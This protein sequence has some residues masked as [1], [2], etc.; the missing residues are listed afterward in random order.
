[1][2]DVYNRSYK[3]LLREIRSSPCFGKIQ[4]CK[5]EFLSKIIYRINTIPII[6]PADGEGLFWVCLVGFAQLGKLFLKCIWQFLKIPK[7]S[8]AIMNKKNLTWL[9]NVY[10]LTRNYSMSVLI[11][12]VQDWKMDW[13]MDQNNQTEKTG[14]KRAAFTWPLD[15]WQRF[16]SSLKGK[17]KFFLIHIL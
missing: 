5:M 8:K 16:Q 14:K 7:M 3:T 11:K 2:W 4:R 9:V 12:T 10:C 13:K 15:T 1:M 17:G 6:N